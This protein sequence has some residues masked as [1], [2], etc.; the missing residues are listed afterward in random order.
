MFSY[1]HLEVAKNG[2]DVIRRCALANTGC[3]M[4]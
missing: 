1:C 2:A 4:N 3:S